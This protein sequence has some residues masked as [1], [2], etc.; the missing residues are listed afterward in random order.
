[1]MKSFLLIWFLLPVFLYGQDADL[2]LT[3]KEVSI[4]AETGRLYGSLLLP[5]TTGKVPVVLIIA[6]SGPTDRNGNNSSMENNSLKMIATGLAV[7]NIASLRYDKRGIAQSADTLL[8]EED[9]RFD[10]FIRD[11]EDWIKFLKS[12]TCFS[13]VIVAGHSEGSLIGMIASERAGA[14]MY[15]SISGMGRPFDVLLKEQL[16]MQG[17]YVFKLSEPIIDS[18]KAGKIAEDTD[19]MLDALFRRQIQPYLISLMAVDP[20]KEISELS[21]PVLIIQGTEDLQVTEEDA[22]C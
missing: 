2:K 22:K 3:E 10:T 20:V 17:D 18:L 7:Q 19:P 15:I 1:M 11:A 8:R 4:P 14:D 16:K 6:G 12:D 21:V 9:I 13:E 5:E